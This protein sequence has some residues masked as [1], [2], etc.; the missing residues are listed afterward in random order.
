MNDQQ[1]NEIERKIQATMDRINA[2]FERSNKRYEKFE[3][4]RQEIYKRMD[5]I[6]KRFVGKV[7]DFYTLSKKGVKKK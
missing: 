4:D 3:K 2:S 1:R 5:S 7:E 6:T